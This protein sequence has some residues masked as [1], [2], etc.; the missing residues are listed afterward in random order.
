MRI[1]RLYPSLAED[2]VSTVRHFLLPIGREFGGVNLGMRPF[3]STTFFGGLDFEHVNLLRDHVAQHAHLIVLLGMSCEVEPG[4]AAQRL[5]SRGKPRRKRS[6]RARGTKRSARPF[7][8][9]HHQVF[10]KSFHPPDVWKRASLLVCE[11]EGSLLE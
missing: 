5:T 1:V 6:A 3:P 8:A 7:H 9:T 4:R 11:R 2:E 10:L